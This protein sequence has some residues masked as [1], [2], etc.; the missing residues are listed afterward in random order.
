MYRGD[1]HRGTDIVD[2]IHRPRGWGDVE[3]C[4]ILRPVWSGD[5]IDKRIRRTDRVSTHTGF[6]GVG[7]LSGRID[8]QRAVFPLNVGQAAAVHRHAVHF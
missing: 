1:V 4:R 8:A 5:G 2:R 6:Q 3:R 7:V